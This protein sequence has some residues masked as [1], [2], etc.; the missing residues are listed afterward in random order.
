MG[1]QVAVELQQHHLKASIEHESTSPSLTYRKKRRLEQ[2]ELRLKFPDRKRRGPT[3]GKKY[4]PG[5]W[6]SNSEEKIKINFMDELRCVVGEK[7]DEFICDCSN[8][9]AGADITEALIFE[10]SMLYK[11][12][13]FRLKEQ[14]YKN[15]PHTIDVGKW[16]WLVY[17]YWNGEKQ[18]HISKVNNENKLKQTETPA[19][20]VRST[21]LLD[22]L[23]LMKLNK[24]LCTSPYLRRQKNYEALKRLHVEEIEKHVEDTLSVK[25][26]Y[27]EV[28]KQKYGYVKRIGPGARPPMKSMVDGESNEARV[29]LSSEIQKLKDDAAARKA[30][31]ASEIETLKASNEELKNSNEELI[32]SNDEL[33]ETVSRIDIEAIKREKKMRDDMMKMFEQM[34]Y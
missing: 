14:H 13:R 32:A 4:D 1:Q 10:C 15:K 22:I 20:G 30:S 17:E 6:N 18:K 24:I 23:S 8:W 7:V 28:F 29:T 19:D 5:M 3:R 27:M 9:V 12:W 31:L 25:D 16:T 11:H 26:A 34:S 33:K 21:N 2:A